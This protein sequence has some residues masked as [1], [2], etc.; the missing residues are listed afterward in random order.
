M[1]R[2]GMKHHQHNCGK[3]IPAVEVPKRY[4]CKPN[5]AARGQPI[6]LDFPALELTLIEH[7]NIGNLLRDKILRGF[8]ANETK[9]NFPTSSTLTLCAE[10][11]T[12]DDSVTQIGV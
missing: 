4:G 6:L 5:D 7:Q 12:A 3:D 11:T 9:A 10:Q 1:N 8:A 2:V